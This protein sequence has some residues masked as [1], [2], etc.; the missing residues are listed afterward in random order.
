MVAVEG[1]HQTRSHYP[2]RLRSG[3][4][5]AQ[6]TIPQY[7]CAV[8]DNGPS[9][10]SSALVLVLSSAP[11]PMHRMERELLLRQRPTYEHT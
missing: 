11:N 4:C 6:C 2:S 8:A 7:V 10:R 1:F 3:E 9:K 5:R